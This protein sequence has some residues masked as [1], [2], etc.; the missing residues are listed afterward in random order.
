MIELKNVTYKYYDG[1]LA[2]DN[3]NL[4]LTAGECYCLTGPNGSGKSTLFR[5]LNG[6]SFPT[7]GKYIFDGTEITE[8]YL[9]N[10]KNAVAFH[11]RIGYLFQNSETQLFTRS[12][13]DEI[14]FGLYQLELPEDEVHKRTEHFL[15]ALSLS[16]MRHRAPFNL[17]GGEKKRCALAAVLAMEPDVL[18]LDEPL[19]GLDEDGEKFVLEC[20]R[21]LK[22]PD[23]LIIVAS[24]NSQFVEEISDE[25]ISLDKDHHI[26][27]T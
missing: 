12:V 25:T 26:S 23:R 1:T 8:K 7:K 22:S 19:N 6:L 15:E 4:K 24:H 3:I 13:E 2:L 16:D 10:K 18:I 21:N 11:S 14:A 5:I 27:V 9:H 17:S 20:I